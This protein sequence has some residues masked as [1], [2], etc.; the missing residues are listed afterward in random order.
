MKKQ[1][2]LLF[3]LLSFSLSQSQT[4]NDGVLEYTVLNGTNVSVKKFNNVCPTGT[5]TIPNTIINNGTTYT[6][7]E[8]TDNAFELCDFASVSIPNSVTT[9][10]N[11]AFYFCHNLTSLTIPNSVIII[12]EN[13]FWACSGLASLTIP[14]SVTIIG[15]YAFSGCAGLTSLT[16]PNSVTTIG[17]GTFEYNNNLTSLIIPNSVTTIGNNAFAACSNITS[18]TIPNSV[19]T[20]G[21][22]A[23][24]DCHNLTSLNIPNSVTTIGD[25][26]FSSGISLTTLVIPNSVTT[27]GSSAFYSCY[28]ITSLT[29]PNSVTT[30]GNLA[31]ND[32]LGLTNVVVN[33]AT[34][35]VVP[36]DIFGSVNV[37]Y[38][39]LN[40]P[41]GTVALYQ[42]ATVW[43][44]FNF[45]VL[46]ANNITENSINV[47]LFPNPVKDQLNITISNDLVLKKILIYN[48]LGQLIKESKTP[49]INVSEL[50]GIYYVQIST[51]KGNITKQIIIE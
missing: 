23:F 12:G 22:S 31:F 10:G 47:Q 8:I 27:I 18:L 43:Q 39:S 34:P 11:N 2:L 28:N 36:S 13:A 1:L 9:I 41:S 40:I 15:D 33:W 42:A 17:D 20:I 6:I 14:N 44:D 49:T 35:L 16:I 46:S 29:I 24:S 37:S 32:C 3:C 48:N 7:T 19:T 45:S 38:I 25:F 50:Q 5:L 21:D 30:I 26:A 51:D 4:F